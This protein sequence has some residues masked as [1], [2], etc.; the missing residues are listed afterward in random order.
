MPVG[1]LLRQPGFGGIVPTHGARDPRPPRRRRPAAPNKDSESEDGRPR[2]E[3]LAPAL[4]TAAACQAR[5]DSE[6][7]VRVRRL[8]GRGKPPQPGVG[9]RRSQTAKAATRSISRSA[10]LNGGR[11]A[12]A[13]KIWAAGGLGRRRT[14]QVAVADIALPDSQLSTRAVLCVR[15]RRFLAQHVGATQPALRHRHLCDN[16]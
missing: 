8:C 7:G 16:A 5:P 14:S 13:A 3:A 1:P 15:N 6:H 2:A 9:P 12:T 4:V 11:R 10:G